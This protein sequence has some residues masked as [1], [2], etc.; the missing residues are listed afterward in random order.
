M[1]KIKLN[2]FI[3]FG[4][5]LLLTSCESARSGLVGAKKNNT[6]EF[7]VKKKNPLVLPPEFSKLPKPTDNKIDEN[8]NNSENN[9]L[10]KLIGSETDKKNSKKNSPGNSSLENSILKT[11]NDD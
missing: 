8:N 7:L 10:K 5:I 6:D 2:I 9:R 1:K 3:I 4:L 11:L